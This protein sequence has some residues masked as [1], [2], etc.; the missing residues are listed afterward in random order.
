MQSNED[1]K[2]SRGIETFERF[3]DSKFLTAFSDRWNCLFGQFRSYLFV[4]NR[5]RK[6]QLAIQFK[7]FVRAR[8]DD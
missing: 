4:P 7:T 6:A 2:S 5:L 8:K 1:K 3:I